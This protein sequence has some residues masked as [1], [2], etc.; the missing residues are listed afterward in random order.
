MSAPASAVA[1]YDQDGNAI[2]EEQAALHELYDHEGNVIAQ[3]HQPYDVAGVR[4]TFH[5]SQN[6]ILIECYT[7]N[8]LRNA[9]KERERAELLIMILFVTEPLLAYGAYRL[10]V[11]K[12]NGR[13]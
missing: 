11:L 4:T 9:T 2:T 8:D 13:T 12:R 10:A 1:Y 6:S 3:Y 7:Y 5:A